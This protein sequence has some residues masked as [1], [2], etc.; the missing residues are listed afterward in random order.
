MKIPKT[1]HAADPVCKTTAADL[2]VGGLLCKE[3]TQILSSLLHPLVCIAP[4]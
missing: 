4:M 2:V 1:L 3:A